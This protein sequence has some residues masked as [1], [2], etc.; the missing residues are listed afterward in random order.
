MVLYIPKEPSGYCYSY[1]PPARTHYSNGTAVYTRYS[2]LCVN[3]TYPTVCASG[4]DEADAK[5]ICG[6]GELNR[7]YVVQPE[8]I[9][10]KLYP[11]ITPAGITNISCPHDGGYF[12]PYLCSYDI[13]HDHCE[14][15]GG[16]AITACVYEGK[17]I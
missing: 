10:G 2:R 13:S 4:L 3:G 14:A 17:G 15:S 16:P 7:G 6:G 1:E 9:Q 5:L 11:P 12:D 8:D